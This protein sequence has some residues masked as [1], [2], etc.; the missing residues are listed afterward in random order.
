VRVSWAVQASLST[1]LVLVI[2]STTDTFRTS[3]LMIGGGAALVASSWLLMVISYAVR[4]FR[5]D[6]EHGGLDFGGSEPPIFDDYL[7]QAVTVSASFAVSDVT[8][9]TTRMR[10]TV[11]SHTLVAFVFNTVILALL[12][13]LLTTVSG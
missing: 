9:T 6:V 11:R 3:V 10:R 2:L 5:E 12:V 8:V 4:Y 1:L 13:S 7:Y